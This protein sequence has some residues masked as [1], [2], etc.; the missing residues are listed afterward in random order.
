MLKKLGL[1]TLISG[2]ALA[3]LAVT[4]SEKAFS[5]VPFIRDC[6]GKDPGVWQWGEA[7]DGCD[8]KR[9]GSV[10]RIK[11]VY[12]EFVFDRTTATDV[13]RRK[14]YVTNV[15]AL[16]RDLATKYIRDR[17]PDVQDDEV[18]AFVKAIH[19][20]AQQET[21]WSHY[22]IASAGGYKLTTGDHNISHGMM[23][24]NQRYH[25]SKDQDRSFD[26]IG[27]VSFGIEHYFDEWENALKAKC[28]MRVKNQSR[29]QTFENVTR[30]AYSAY[31]GGPGAICR[32]TNPKHP[33]A[34]NDR[35]Y[36]KKLKEQNWSEF[37]RDENHKLNVNLDCA[38][39]GDDFCA[40]AKDRLNEFIGSRALVMEDGSTCV[41]TDG[42]T[43]QCAKDVR[44]FTCLA[45]MSEEVASATP[46]KVKSSDRQIMEMKRTFVENRLELCQK[47]FPD[48]ASIGDVVTTN[49]AIA[50]K[51]EIGGRTVGF[52]KKGQALQVLDVDVELDEAHLRNY[53][54]RLSNK[55]EGWIA[56][57]TKD[58]AEKIA[59]VTHLQMAP[60]AKTVTQYLPAK[61]GQVVIAKTDG[62]SLL[63]SHE[64]DDWSP[65][66]TT[67]AKLT[68]GT[69]AE[70]Q[71]VLISS[72]ANEIWLQVK[73]PAGEGYVY[74]GR[75]YPSSTVD[76][77]VT[78][79]Q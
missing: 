78:V 48:I 61:G 77:W 73:T 31:N 25:A 67:I 43:L 1:L 72:A 56:A 24:I 33:W 11:Y 59:T 50:V 68:P 40:V 15:N 44:V 8:A 13:E 38:R 47:A 26:I 39:S 71:D 32:W 18:A 9:Y 74:A 79:R 7:A 4:S 41:T 51:S 60:P 58:T 63:S 21:Y 10:S 65:P 6:Q 14:D 46:L 34:K 49:V 17:R 57:G 22:R 52:T 37:V 30:S 54:V 62:L 42:K 35:N 29:E 2:M 12:P 64:S 19:A 3:A 75:T 27:N 45:G 36:L 69:V 5:N 70:V 66:Q 23:Q 16:L 28:T 20:V 55:V 53:R 76:Q